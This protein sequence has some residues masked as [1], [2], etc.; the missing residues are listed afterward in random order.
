MSSNKENDK[1]REE[2]Q[3]RISFTSLAYFDDLGLRLFSVA[4]LSSALAV[5]LVSHFFMISLLALEQIYRQ[6]ADCGVWAYNYHSC[7]C[8]PNGSTYPSSR[9]TI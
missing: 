3:H 2:T 5:P 1:I 9:S 8:S 6:L 7:S 4:L